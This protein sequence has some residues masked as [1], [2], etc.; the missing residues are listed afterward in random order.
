MS[1]PSYTDPVKC[2]DCDATG[3]NHKWARIRSDGWFFTKDSKAYC[4]LH[5]PAWVS[6]WRAKKNRA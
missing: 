5:T 4:P 6:E 1:L 2:E 3:K